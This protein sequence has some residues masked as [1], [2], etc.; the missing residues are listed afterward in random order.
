M[1]SSLVWF[2]GEILFSF[3]VNINSPLSPAILWRSQNHNS[4]LVNWSLNTSSA[5]LYTWDRKSRSGSWGDLHSR[6]TA[7]HSSSSS[8]IF[9]SAHTWCEVSLC[10]QWCLYIEMGLHL[11]R[12]LRQGELP[13]VDLWVRAQGWQK[14]S[15]NCWGG[16]SCEVV[17][18]WRNHLVEK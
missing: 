5:P 1:L 10:H 8:Q 2:A 17:L 3:N 13:G 9:L 6:I 7:C 11:C 4:R 14:A 15:K 12:Q 18:C 16:H